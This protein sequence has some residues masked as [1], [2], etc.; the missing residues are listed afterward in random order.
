V[1]DLASRISLPCP[2]LCEPSPD[3]REEKKVAPTMSAGATAPRLVRRHPA[4]P[5]RHRR[6]PDTCRRHP[7]SLDHPGHWSLD[8]DRARAHTGHPR[9]RPLQPI[10]RPLRA[11]LD[12]HHSPL[13]R[14]HPLLVSL[15]TV[16]ARRRRRPRRPPPRPPLLPGV[17][18]RLSN[19]RGYLADEEKLGVL[20]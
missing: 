2:A 8:G 10:K 7:C 19:F 13:P 12:S 9:A 17:P 1:P 14:R 3:K 4:T 16:R 5:T 15:F 6:H 20:F 11:L 18:G